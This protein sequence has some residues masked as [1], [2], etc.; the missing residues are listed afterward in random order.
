[1]ARRGPPRRYGERVARWRNWAGDQRCRPAVVARPRTVAEVV[2][3][4]RAARGTV[5]VAGAG[6]SFGDLVATDGTL[7]DL[8]AL[9]GLRA[10]DPAGGLVRVAAGTRLRAVNDL[11]AGHGLALPNLGDVDVQTVAGALATG[12]H[13]TGARLGNL[14]TGVAGLE[15]VTADG[16][17][18]ACTGE[19]LRAARISLGAL[20][21]VTEVTLRVVPA[22][23]LRG[24]D[25]RR[26]CPRSWPAWTSSS[27]TTTTS[28]S[29][30][31]RTPTSR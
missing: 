26:R 27:T 8:R 15:L 18:L 7:L 28:S 16:S 14:A 13:G 1:M 11:L 12:T 19:T 29:T 21:V 17:V 25:G 22:F 23:R 6:H 30:C 4:V 24:D 9:T 20:G 31:S 2:D 5:R 10:V 3:A